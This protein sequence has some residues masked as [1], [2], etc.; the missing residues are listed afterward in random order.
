MGG[1]LDTAARLPVTW[2]F[3]ASGITFTDPI[4]LSL[5][6]SIAGGRRFMQE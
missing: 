4:R 5:D 1:L 3:D 2:I 6:A